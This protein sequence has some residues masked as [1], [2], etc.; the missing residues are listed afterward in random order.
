[1]KT[2]LRPPGGRLRIIVLGYIVRGPLGGIAWHHLQYLLG[3]AALGHE[4]YFVEDS[5]DYATCYDP[6]RQTLDTD[7]SYGLAFARHALDRVGFGERWAY[8]D[9]HQAQWHGPCA[10]R[11][12]EL[13][14]SA[15]VMINV[16]GINPVRPWLENIPLRVMIDTDPV[17]TQID[18]IEDEAKRQLAD[19]HNAFFSFGES[20]GLPGCCIPDDGRPWL[21]TRQPVALDA[22]TATQGPVDGSYTTIMMW[23]SY[24][25]REFGGIGFGM[26]SE[27]MAPYVDMPQRCKLPFELALGGPTSPGARLQ[28]AGWQIRDPFEVTRDPWIYQDFMRASKAEFSIAKQGYVVS[29]SGWFSERSTGYLASGR[30]VIVQDTGFSRHL[31]VGEG[32]FAFSS[33]DEALAAIAEVEANYAHHCRAARELVAAHFDARSVLARLLDQAYGVR[34]QP[35]ATG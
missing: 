14:R 28:A 4:V 9:A 10:A 1:M 25:R 26:K 35:G 27:S 3:F 12:P 22:W 31:P 19:A 32:L 34:E 5:D 20:F 8:H 33:P 2:P 7:P 11:M 23:D 29:A 6:S 21:P 15:D 17:F 13:C 18:F 24:E 16:S 30:P